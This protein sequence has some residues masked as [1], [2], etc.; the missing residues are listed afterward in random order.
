MTNKKKKRKWIRISKLK[1]GKE[2]RF[3]IIVFNKPILGF[4]SHKL[5]RAVKRGDTR[6]IK[7]LH[8]YGSKRHIPLDLK[9]IKYV[10]S[11][12]LKRKRKKDK[13]DRRKD[14]TV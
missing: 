2:W 12:A 9:Y 14:R 5:P 7:H 1:R 10:L 13:G 3:R 11:D 4:N 8:I 6:P